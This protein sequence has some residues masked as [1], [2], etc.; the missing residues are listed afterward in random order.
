MSNAAGALKGRE[1][2]IANCLTAH[3]ATEENGMVLG[4]FDPVRGGKQLPGN[5]N[6]QGKERR[7]NERM[8]RTVVTFGTPEE[9]EMR[10][11]D[12]LVPACRRMGCRHPWIPAGNKGYRFPDLCEPAKS[13]QIEEGILTVWGAND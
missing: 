6:T 13:E 7:M 8:D 1:E 11:M 2:R 10:E 5:A 9:H 4:T 3:Q 12:Y